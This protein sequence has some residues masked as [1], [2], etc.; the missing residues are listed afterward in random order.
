MLC[1]R[2]TE[3]PGG[4]RQG[5]EEAGDVA[6]GEMRRM[7]AQGQ[8]CGEVRLHDNAGMPQTRT[9]NGSDW[10]RGDNSEMP[11]RSLVF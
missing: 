4:G 3:K 1:W 11:G 8:G 5:E 10:R 9:A 2:E 6:Q 7:S